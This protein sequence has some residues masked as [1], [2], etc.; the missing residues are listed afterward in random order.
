MTQTHIGS[1]RGSTYSTPRWVKVL[2][3][4]TLVV[5]L[6]VLVVLVTGLG[7]EHGPGRHIPSGD[8]GGDTSLSEQGAQPDAPV[9]H[10]PPAGH[11]G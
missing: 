9:G 11:G 6:L 3:I 7:G 2:G 4:I 1:S 10:T 5:I 8:A